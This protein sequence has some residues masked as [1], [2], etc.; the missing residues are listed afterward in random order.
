VPLRSKSSQK[1]FDHRDFSRVRRADQGDVW[2]CPPSPTGSLA[3]RRPVPEGTLELLPEFCRYIEEATDP[4]GRSIQIPADLAALLRE[5]RPTPITFAPDLA[6]RVGYRGTLALKRED[7][8]R[9]GS[10][11]FPA[12][13]AGCY[14]AKREGADSVVSYSLAGNWAVAVAAAAQIFSLQCTIIVSS[15]IAAARRPLI[16]R[17]RNLGCN[18]EIV[19]VGTG[20][21]AIDILSTMASERTR[22]LRNARLITGC[23]TKHSIVFSSIIGIETR[24]QVETGFPEID[25]LVTAT[26]CGASTLG[27][28]VP[29]LDDEPVD[30][31]LI[32]AEVAGFATPNG[33]ELWDATSVD[34]APVDN[35]LPNTG[36]RT[37]RKLPLLESLVRSGEVHSVPI[38]PQDAQDAADLLRS[39]ENI[40]CAV[41]TGYAVA[42]ALSE[43]SRNRSAQGILICI[44]GGADD[45][46]LN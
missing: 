16:E 5:G 26:G 46:E 44:S 36:L 29:F 7:L 6:A 40:S 43:I 9:T 15:D 42:T 28:F 1:S 25:T 33:R 31:K 39:A 30:I 18:V 17:C 37:R 3:G 4:A 2:A 13:L 10:Q 32:A 20:D 35:R 8:G 12:A 41:E 19:D 21:E 27:L 38:H 34:H 45:R 11:K 23:N 24:T 22:S 14:Y